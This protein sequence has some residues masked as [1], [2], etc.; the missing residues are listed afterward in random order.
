MNKLCMGCNNDAATKQEESDIDMIE[1]ICEK[2]NH[3]SIHSQKK[4]VIEIISIF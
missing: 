3:Q 1:G 4:N 2:K